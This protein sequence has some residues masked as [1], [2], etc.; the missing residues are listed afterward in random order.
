VP[1]RRPTR[2]VALDA[3]AATGA[4]VSRGLGAPRVRAYGR[5][6][7]SP[8]VLVPSPL[9]RNLRDVDQVQDAL[10]RLAESL[11]AG[12][13]ILV[14]P[15]G[16]ARFLILEA[17]GSD[18]PADYARYRLGQGLPYPPEEAVVDVLRLGRGRGVG[19]AVRRAV[20]E[21]YEAAA[22]RAGLT[23]DRVDLAPLA[24]L[25]RLLRRPPGRGVGVDV[26][27]GDAALSLAVFRDGGLLAFRSRRRDPGAGELERVWREVER[28]A[29]L[30]GAGVLPRVRIVGSGAAA[31]I[32]EL[33]AT[34]AAVEAGWATSRDGLPVEPAEL[35]WLGAS[36][37]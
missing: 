2:I 5:I 28:S 10:A 8:G 34:G 7:L 32:R 30:T 21:E 15:D 9:D 24:A 31:A 12:R 36:R 17:P 37:A 33:S 23:P 13:T 18:V 29:A 14:L 27:L 16:V 11:G 4:V 25:E 6:D 22:T 20:V 26:I 3:G 19:A 35:A 1:L